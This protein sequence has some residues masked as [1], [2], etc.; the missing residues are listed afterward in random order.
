ME[1]KFSTSEAAY[2]Y[3]QAVF[4]GD[5]ETAELIHGAP[6][7]YTANRL[8]RKITGLNIQEWN[9]KKYSVM[10]D[11]LTA[12]FT[13]N[14]TLAADLKTTGKKVIG[15]AGKHPYYA[16]GVSVNHKDALDP[17]KWN[18]NGNMLGKILVNIRDTILA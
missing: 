3:N 2:L 12:K 18:T 6:D 5:K 10:N 13:Q 9:K 17:T 15:E 8:S 11:I 1:R 14:P 4:A 7:A 16:T